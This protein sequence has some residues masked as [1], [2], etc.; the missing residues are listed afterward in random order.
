M[1]SPLRA[2]AT[3]DKSLAAEI[4]DYERAFGY[5]HSAGSMPLRTLLR[6]ERLLTGTEIFSAETG[7]GKSTIFFSRI[8]ER[9]KVFCFDDRGQKASSVDYF[10]NCPATRSDRLDLVFG[11]TQLTLP[12]HEDHSRYDLVLIDGPHGFPFPELEYY[13]FYP[14]LKTDGLLVVD[15]I[16]I[17]T[18]SRLADFLSEDQMF[19]KVEFVG[20][21]AIFRRTDAPVFDPLGDGWWLQ[22]FNRRRA[23]FSKDIYL[24]DGKKRAPISFEGIY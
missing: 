10:M 6:I 1:P 15:D 7:C 24:E 8:A 21:T 12:R 16:H 2:E 9:H 11:P 3:R 23:S 18:I 22:A 17:P 20:S 14:H 13:Y 5:A 19:E 4:G